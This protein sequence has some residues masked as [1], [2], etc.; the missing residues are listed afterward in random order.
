MSNF[1]KKYKTILKNCLSNGIERDDRTGVGSY[2][3]FNQTLKIN[4]S[5]KF[6]IITGKKIYKKIFDTEFDWFINGETNIKRF[7]DA[8]VTIWDDWADSNGNLGPVY[9]YQMLN[10][11]G[12]NINQLDNLINSLK[13]NKDSRRHIIS[14]WN[15]I[16]LNEMALPPCYLYFQFYIDKNSKLNMFVVQR[17]GDLFLGIPYD[18][19]LFSKILLYIASKTNLKANKLEIQIIDAHIYKNQ[20]EPICEYLSQPIYDLPKYKYNN[21]ILELID[22]KSGPKITAKVAV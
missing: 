13:F 20:I 21:E 19:A 14:L 8:N 16:Q 2:S 17:S 9:G 4:I 22:Y 6:P 15:P 11:N 3:L 10:Y 18:V 7:K 5:K 1:E 12:N